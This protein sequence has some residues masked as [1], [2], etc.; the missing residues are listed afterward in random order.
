MPNPIDVIKL[1][2]GLRDNF[3]SL[4]LFP[5]LKAQGEDYVRIPVEMVDT[6]KQTTDLVSLAISVLESNGRTGMNTCETCKH[7][8]KYTKVANGY[9]DCGLTYPEDD[10]P[11]RPVHI[12]AESALDFVVLRTLGTVFG[13]NQWQPKEG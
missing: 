13:C 7:W 6:L 3:R 9:A 1:S 10:T 11:R 8:G 2:E 5:L 12:M 4:S